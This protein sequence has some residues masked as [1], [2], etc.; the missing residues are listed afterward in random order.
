MELAKNGGLPSDCWSALAFSS[1]EDQAIIILR[2]A[3]RD[4]NTSRA[5]LF[6]MDSSAMKVRRRAQDL[7]KQFNRSDRV[8][9][10]TA[11]DGF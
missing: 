4:S 8:A 7:L 6:G 9:Q 11:D 3:R 1:R 2:T 10:V 5:K